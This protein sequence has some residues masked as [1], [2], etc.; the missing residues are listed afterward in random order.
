MEAVESL[1][2]QTVQDIQTLEHLRAQIAE[3]TF[4]N[5]VEILEVQLV[6]K[7]IEF[8]QLQ[9]VEKNVQNP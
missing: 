7:T 5:N 6:R 8:P 4:E 3:K 1:E 9:T 2:A